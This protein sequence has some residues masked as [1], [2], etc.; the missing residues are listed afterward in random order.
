MSP[1]LA[2]FIASCIVWKSAGPSSST[3]QVVG[4]A[5]TGLMNRRLIAV[6]DRSSI[7]TKADKIIF[8]FIFLPPL[9]RYVF[10]AFNISER[11]FYRIILPYISLLDSDLLWV[12]V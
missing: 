1:S 6:H 11:F 5:L 12:S 4:V 10:Q 7:E 3:V 2:A 8:L 9:Y